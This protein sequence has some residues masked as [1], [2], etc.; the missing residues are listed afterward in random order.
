MSK[1]IRYNNELLQSYFLKNNITSTTDYSKVNLTREYRIKEK[2]VECDDLC[3]KTFRKFIATGC[4][5]KKHM[6]QISITKAKAT[7]LERYG[8]ECSLQ[9]EDVKTKI[10]ATNMERLGVEYPTQSEAVRNKGKVTCLKKYGVE[11]PTQSKD[12]KT[13]MK[14]TNIERLGVEYPTQSEDVRNK[15]KV[16]C[17]KNFGVENPFQS[18]EIKD[19]IKATNM[20][21][22]GV[23]YASQSE[24]I[25]DKIK[26][27]NLE[28]YGFECSLQSQDVRD[29]CKA[30]NMERF[31][32]E[33]PFQS[34]EIKDKIKATNLERL[35]VEWSLQSKDIRNKGKVTCLKKYGVENPM[36]NA[37]ISE[38]ASKNAYKGYNYTFPSGRIE[39]IQG[40]ENYMLNDL[41]FKENVDEN[42]IIVKRDEVPDI[43][44]EDSNGAKHRYFVDCFI[45]SQNRCIETKSTWT[46]EKK[47]DIIYLK[48]QSLKDTGYSC[49]IWIYNSKG[50]IVEKIM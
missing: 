11:Y 9:S 28:N 42:D 35:G 4:Y 36:Q 44:Y 48:Q 50:E 37:E 15:G 33:N 10:K 19:K 45:K 41:L 23:E 18:E 13:K 20:E 7:N 25:K 43:W 22:L 14:A 17:L 47:Q 39:R 24:E 49:E 16:T 1:P 30:T 29:K 38:K 46:A 40:Y 2:C 32:F 26:A 31:G 12:V 5:C 8:F 3:D 27:T 21:R 34:E 6:T